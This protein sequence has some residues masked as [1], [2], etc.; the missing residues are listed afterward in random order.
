MGS[1][2]ILSAHLKD[3]AW[4]SS[5]LSA[6]WRSRRMGRAGALPFVCLPIRSFYKSDKLRGSG[7]RAPERHSNGARPLRLLCGHCSL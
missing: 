2:Y 1:W 6:R 4:L 7:G 5:N 3:R